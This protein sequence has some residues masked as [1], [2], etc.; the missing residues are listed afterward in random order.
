MQE[1]ENYGESHRLKG[2]S[3]VLRFLGTGDRIASIEKHSGTEYLGCTQFGW[4]VL[5]F[6]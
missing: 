4:E 2:A 1:G 6:W 3:I 5:V